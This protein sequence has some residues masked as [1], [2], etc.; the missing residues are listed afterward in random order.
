MGLKSTDLKQAEGRCRSGSLY[1]RCLTPLLQRDLF[2]PTVEHF[3]FF[4]LPF[5]F[6]IIFLSAITIVKAGLKTSPESLSLEVV[7]SQPCDGGMWDEAR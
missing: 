4:V 7:S 6:I 3:W 2:P 5:Y 1:V